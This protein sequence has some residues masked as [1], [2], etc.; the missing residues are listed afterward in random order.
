MITIDNRFPADYIITQQIIGAFFA[1]INSYVVF[2]EIR[3]RCLDAPNFASWS[4]KWLSLL[5]I[6]GGF[7]HAF[8]WFLH[9]FDGLCG[10]LFSVS[11]YINTA[12]PIFVGLYQLSR[13]YQCFAH[14]NVAVGYPKWMFYILA[15]FGILYLLALIPFLASRT[16]HESCGLTTKYEFYAVYRGWDSRTRAIWSATVAAVY[17]IWDI[18]TSLLFVFKLNSVTT[19]V[20]SKSVGLVLG[21][22]RN[23]TRIVILTIFYMVIKAFSVIWWCFF[24]YTEQ[25]IL[26]WKMQYYTENAF[27]MFSTTAISYAVFWMQPHNSREYGRFLQ[28]I[29]CFKLHFC[30]C[31][32]REDVVDHRDHFLSDSKLDLMV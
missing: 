11:N 31:C 21:I 14:Q 5:C 1:I 30:C 24:N 12:L 18:T 29:V 8:I 28:R 17:L 16:Q 6:I 19:P 27:Y 9:Y 10:F 2:K 15:T 4:L 23:M 26:H 13:L 22:R 20:S 3:K 7:L 25:D 32:Y